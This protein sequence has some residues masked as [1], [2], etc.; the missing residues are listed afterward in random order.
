MLQEATQAFRDG[1]FNEAELILEK[2]LQDDI[3]ASNI[4]FK[5]GISYAKANRFMEASKVFYSLQHYKND[6]VKIPLNCCQF[7]SAT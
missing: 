3:N 5:L 1:N 2:M 6:D 7:R 4:I